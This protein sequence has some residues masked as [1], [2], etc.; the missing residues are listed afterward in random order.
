MPG[1]DAELVRVDLDRSASEAR[2]AGGRPEQSL[3]FLHS[4][5]EA[6]ERVAGRSLDDWLAEVRGGS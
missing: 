6:Y 5:K 1:E 2:W 3:G 4:A